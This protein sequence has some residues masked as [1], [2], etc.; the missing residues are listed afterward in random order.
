[1]TAQW[2]RVK[3][4]VDKALGMHIFHFEEAL[5]G[6]KHRLQ[7]L[8]GYDSCPLCGHIWPK[9][10]TGEIN[11]FDY[12]ARELAALHAVHANMDHYAKRTGAPVK[13]VRR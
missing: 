9:T 2:Q 4:H 5:S 3:H 10:N 1:V 6:A 13:K 7:I 12:E 8:I 11:P